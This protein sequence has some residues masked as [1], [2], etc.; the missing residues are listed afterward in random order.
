MFDNLK[1]GNTRMFV[2][3]GL[4]LSSNSME[5]IIQIVIFRISPAVAHR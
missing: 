3:C 5:F 2:P 4:I 1:E